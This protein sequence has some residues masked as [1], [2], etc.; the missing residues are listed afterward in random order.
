MPTRG[1]RASHH[2][3]C[4]KNPRSLREVL[5]PAILL[6]RLAAAAEEVCLTAYVMDTYCIDRGTLLDNP[7]V[8]TLDHPEKHSI[9]CL[10]DVARCYD[11]GFELLVEPPAAVR[12]FKLDNAGFAKAMALARATGSTGH[13]C[14]TCTGDKATSDAAG[15]RATVIGTFDPDDTR[16]PKVLAVTSVLPASTPCPKNISGFDP[17]DGTTGGGGQ[18]ALVWAHGGLMLL[19]WGMILPSGVITAR[20]RAGVGDPKWFIRHRFMQCLGML[21]TLSGFIIAVTQFSVF[22]EGHYAPAK[23]HG[24][25]GVIVMTLGILQPINGFLRPHH[26]KPYRRVW[27]L[28]H[29]GSGYFAVTLAVPTICLGAV[30]AG[31][32]ITPAY[33][34]IYGVA[35]VGLVAYAGVLWNAGKVPS[36]LPGGGAR[37]KDAKPGDD[38][39]NPPF[40]K[41]EVN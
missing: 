21:L 32:M 37:G 38:A 29:K 3:S 31:G 1:R 30:V 33:L 28:L 9:H 4:E 26:G 36:S 7:S 8:V 40:V 6:I 27:E 5:V 17:K 12:A 20:C 34:S 39:G 15:F 41:V 24:V 11:S 18:A 35:L 19:G 10:V 25:M 2:S 22:G 14:S 13:G 16:T 23:A